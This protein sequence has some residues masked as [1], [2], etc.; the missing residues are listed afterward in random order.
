MNSINSRRLFSLGLISLLLPKASLASTKK[1]TKKKASKPKPVASKSFR[2]C[3]AAK[4]AGYSHMRAGQ[5]GYSKN[6]D[7]DGD[8]VACDK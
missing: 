6:L 1:K 7:R 5:A 3:K 2:S 8:G 4:K